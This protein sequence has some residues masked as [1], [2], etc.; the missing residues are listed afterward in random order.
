MPRLRVLAGESPSSL[1]PISANNSSGH[2]LK[3]S[4]FDGEIAVF[5]KDYVNES[6]DLS[7]SDAYF[8]SEERRGCTWSIQARG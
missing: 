5:L 4:A 7:S 8:G 1:K 2:A 6:G 3:T